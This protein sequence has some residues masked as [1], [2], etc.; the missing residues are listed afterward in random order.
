M[1]YIL[2]ALLLFGVAFGAVFGAGA[3]EPIEP[4]HVVYVEPAGS[5][6]TEEEQQQAYTAINDAALYWNE[7]TGT[8]LAVVDTKLITTSADVYNT[9][10][11]SRPYFTTPDITIFVIDNADRRPLL[12]NSAAESQNYYRVIWVV[13]SDASPAVIAHEFGH[14]VYHLPHQYQSTL[15]IMSLDPVPAYQNHTIGCD[16]LSVLGKPCHKIYMPIIVR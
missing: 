16:S 5:V 8:A 15:D 6:F 9:F 2:I 12:E 4:I 3:Q 11:Y 1:R 13:M 14:I 7:L 10:E